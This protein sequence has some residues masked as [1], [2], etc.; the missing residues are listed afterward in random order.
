MKP[1]IRKNVREQMQKNFICQSCGMPL[2]SPSDHGTESDG[3]VS[4]LYCQFC[5]QNG[6]FTEPEI[7]IDQMAEH[8]APIMNQMF[9][10]PLEKAGAFSR[11]QLESLFRWSGKVI[12]FC[13]SCGMPLV[14]DSDAGTEKDGTKSEKYCT[15]CYQNGVFTE[16]DLTR[17]TMIKKYA[18][19]LSAQFEVPLPKAEEMVRGFAGA[20]PR[21]RY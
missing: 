17:E 12:P 11:G 1:V 16:P 20:L 18:P 4:S 5:Y 2:G 21:W 7:T 6:V 10:M 3:S 13:E 19:F 8:V 14:N 15:H 9:E